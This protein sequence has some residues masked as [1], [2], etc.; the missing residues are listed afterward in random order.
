MRAKQKHLAKNIT[1]NLDFLHV[2]KPCVKGLYSFMK[3]RKNLNLK[4]H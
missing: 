2:S 3:Q 4:N 1:V